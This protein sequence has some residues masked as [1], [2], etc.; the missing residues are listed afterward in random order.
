VKIKVEPLF[1]SLFIRP[2]I[3][4]LFGLLCHTVLVLRLFLVGILDGEAPDIN[5]I[6]YRGDDIKLVKG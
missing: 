5:V 4:F 6:T 3:H 2:L 1:T